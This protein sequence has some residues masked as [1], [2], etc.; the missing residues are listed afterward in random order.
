MWVTTFVVIHRKWCSTTGIL[1]QVH[2]GI[3][4]VQDNL[5]VKARQFMRKTPT[6]A[7]QFMRG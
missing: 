3:I 5:C 6:K 7:R 1:L 4:R 2:I